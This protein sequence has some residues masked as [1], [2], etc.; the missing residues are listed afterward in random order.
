MEAVPSGRESRSGSVG[1][2]DVLAPRA[3]Q[4][5]SVLAPAIGDY[6]PRLEEI[7]A[8]LTAQHDA[9]AEDADEGGRPG[10]SNHLAEDAQDQQAAQSVAA[11]RA[12]VRR[13]LRAV[14]YALR[15]V[16]S[17]QYGICE[18]CG[19]G[20]PP[21]RLEIVPTATVCVSCQA[22]REDTRAAH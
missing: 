18:D 15:R 4:G 6:R 12:L 19:R 5:E 14:E 21:R 9:L 11:R 7:L 8:A 3:Q 13:E 16:D 10:Y 1:M 22:R 17:G 2:G 20:I